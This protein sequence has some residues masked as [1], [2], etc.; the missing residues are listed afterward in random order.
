MITRFLAK[1]W[2]FIAPALL[3]WLGLLV[4]LWRNFV[5]G[6]Q[7]KTAIEQRDI[8][9]RQL[10]IS[11]SKATPHIASRVDYRRYPIEGRPDVVRYAIY[12]EIYNDGDLVAR[13]VEG[14]WNLTASNG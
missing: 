12:T 5:M 1:W 10:A 2:P 11:V 13:N 6:K 8:A 3:G 9:Q 14:K 4:S 7:L